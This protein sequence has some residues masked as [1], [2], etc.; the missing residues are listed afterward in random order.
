MSCA[1]SVF[2]LFLCVCACLWLVWH[3]NNGIGYISKVK[4][5]RSQLVLGLL[6]TF[7]GYTVPEFS[8]H[9]RPTQPSHPS[10]GEHWWFQPSLLKKW[11]VLFSNVSCNQDCWHAGI[12]FYFVSVC[13][14]E[15][16]V[17]FK[18]KYLDEILGITEL[19]QI[20]SIV[21]PGVF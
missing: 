21:M 13:M 9:S 10:V 20:S 6:T 11:Q 18:Y 17:I 14:S 7:G 15:L 4:L 2:L 16:T 3:S 12:Y 1:L 5:R 8:W 19:M